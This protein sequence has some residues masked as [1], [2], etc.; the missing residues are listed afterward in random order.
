MPASHRHLYRAGAG[1]AFY[2][3]GCQFGLRL[4]HVLLHL[5]R[6]LHQA[7]QSALHHFFILPS[8]L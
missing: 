8:L 2:F 4:L 1:L 5:L 7:A 3:H 6:L